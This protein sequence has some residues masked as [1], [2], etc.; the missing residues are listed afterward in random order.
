[1]TSK[2][3]KDKLTEHIALLSIQGIGRG[4]F[5]SLVKTFGSIQNV[6]NAT[7]NALESVS[8]IS[9]SL[10]KSIKS[11]VDFDKA[12]EV[13]EKIIQLGWK[14]HFYNDDNFPKQ[15]Y[16][17]SSKDIPPI[18][19]SI[20][21]E[22]IPTDKLIGIVG[23]RHATETGKQFTFN[24]AGQL[25]SS[26]IIVVSGM[27]EGIDAAAHKGAL[28]SGGHTVAV[29][30][31]SLDIVYP[32][33][34]KEL[35]KQIAKHGTIFSEYL[36]GTDPVR[37][38]FPER[39]RIIAGLSDGVIV[40]EAG[41]KS[42]AL[43][44]AEQALT[45]NKELF[46][47]PGLPSSKMSIGSNQLIKNGA[48]L[49]TSIDDIFETMPRLKGEIK[50]KKF[51]Q[52]PDMTKTEQEIINLFT[53]GPQQVDK[54]SREINLPVPELMEFLLALELKGIVKEIS[55]KQFILSED[56]I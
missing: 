47:V 3:L 7:E 18:L 42:G 48:T 38:Y 19:F 25:A 33:S 53:S 10:A 35:A 12:K 27:A 22:I 40:V 45:Y 13:A 5:H 37:A 11:T 44:T 24:L 39:N 56:Y 14:V 20:G 2:D 43:I 17:I 31:S 15:L 8:G 4:R 23:S 52:L 32:P 1:M 16:N 51:K 6:F 54:I 50:A 55:G 30:G 49:L 9:N 36:P 29:W 21:K 46:A 41:Q 34:N 26:D 28:E